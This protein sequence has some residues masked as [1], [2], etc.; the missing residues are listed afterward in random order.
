MYKI[1]ERQELEI[2]FVKL[3]GYNEKE[4][5]DKFGNKIYWYTNSKS[6]EDTDWFKVKARVYSGHNEDGSIKY[7]SILNP[8]KINKKENTHD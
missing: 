3:G 7:Y 5:V 2:K 1:D 6:L 4:Y 8:R